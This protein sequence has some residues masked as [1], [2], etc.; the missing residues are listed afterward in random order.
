M[1]VLNRRETMHT[2]ESLAKALFLECAHGEPGLDEIFAD[3]IVKALMSSDHVA[4][5]DVER[6]LQSAERP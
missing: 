5:V 6:L 4:R 1:I 2:Q 3:P